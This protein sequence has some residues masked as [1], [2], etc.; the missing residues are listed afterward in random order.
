MK[1]AL[2]LC[3]RDD[4]GVYCCSFNAPSGFHAACWNSQG[5]GFESH[6]QNRPLT[7]EL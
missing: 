3:N 5:T 6:H 2:S 4:S 7:S 1:V